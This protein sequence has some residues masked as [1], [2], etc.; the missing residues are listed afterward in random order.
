[1]SHQQEWT[2]L[3]FDKDLKLRML[4]TA[5]DYVDQ[6]TDGRM[7]WKNYYFDVNEKVFQQSQERAP[8]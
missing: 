6:L 7:T 4:E 3:A 5:D 1:M 2:H 8:H